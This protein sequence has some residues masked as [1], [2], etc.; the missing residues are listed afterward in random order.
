MKNNQDQVMG[1]TS[2]S[3]EE[4]T[5]VTGGWLPIA[6]GVGLILSFINDFGDVREGFA[7]GFNGVPPRY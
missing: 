5:G 1:L 6:L 7:D 4:C 2:L 3:V